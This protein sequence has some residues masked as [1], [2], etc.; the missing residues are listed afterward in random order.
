[1]MNLPPRPEGMPTLCAADLP[2]PAVFSRFH[3]FL[4]GVFSQWHE[5][6][7]TIGGLDFNTAE[8]WMMVNKAVLFGDQKRA[9]AIMASADPAEQKRFG[10]MVES[11]DSAIWDAYKIDIVVAG[12]R[13]KFAQNPGAR[14]QLV[15]T[16]DAMLVEANPRDWNWG[17]G[18]A[19]DHPDLGKPS[20]WPGAN[21][22]GRILTYLRDTETYSPG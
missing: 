3:P 18:I 20:G 9:H 8:Q 15:A 13:A 16:G 4:R 10:Q 11:F 12:N 21:L 5:T 19:A 14:R 1:M 22:L 6:P 2:D 7:F 17:A